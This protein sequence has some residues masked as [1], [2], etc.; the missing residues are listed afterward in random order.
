[1]R[2]AKTCSIDHW[3]VIFL[4][5]TEFGRAFKFIQAPYPWSFELE[6]RSKMIDW[7]D[8][9]WRLLLVLF[10]LFST[11]HHLQPLCVFFLISFW[12]KQIIILLVLETI[13]IYS[14][15]CLF[16]ALFFLWSRFLFE[17]SRSVVSIRDHSIRFVNKLISHEVAIMSR[18]SKNSWIKVI[19]QR[20][21]R[22]NMISQLLYGVRARCN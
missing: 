14:S 7:C 16:A 5:V 8:D 10:T 15:N 4:I 11:C 17:G 22:R 1:M 19:I 12:R 13:R 21:V 9:V 20:L 3:N 6:C 18:Q 2:S